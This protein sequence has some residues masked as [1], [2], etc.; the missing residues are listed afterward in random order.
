[1]AES[2]SR[3]SKAKVNINEVLRIGSVIERTNIQQRSRVRYVII[4]KAIFSIKEG[5]F[6]KIYPKFLQI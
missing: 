1:M 4:V 3:S 5:K 2:K 6:C